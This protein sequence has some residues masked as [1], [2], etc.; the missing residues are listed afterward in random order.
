MASKL[1]KI[2]SACLGSQTLTFLLL[3]VLRYAA[4][5]TGIFYGFYHQAKLTT[6]AKLAAADREY[7]H[8]QSLIDKAKAEFS[9]Q[10]LPPS[11]KTEGGDST[12]NPTFEQFHKSEEGR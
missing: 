9:K 7:Q 8:K 10:N 1:D 2:S 3:Q 12:L 11:S 4:L 6:A 5:G